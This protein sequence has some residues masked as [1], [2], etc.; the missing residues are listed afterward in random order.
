MGT[1]LLFVTPSF[2][3]GAARVA[4]FWGGLTEYS[5]SVTPELADTRALRADLMVVGLDMKVAICQFKAGE[6]QLT[7]DYPEEPLVIGR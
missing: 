2:A 5:N 6:E 3:R 7:I 4:D 1:D